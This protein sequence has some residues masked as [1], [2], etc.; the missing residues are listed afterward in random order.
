MKFGPL[1]LDRAVGAISAHAIKVDGYVLKKG[2]RVTEADVA[3]L[4]RRGVRE[5][6][7]AELAPDDVPED[8]AAHRIARALAGENLRCDAP[9]T[10][11]SN[12]FAERA[13]VVWSSAPAST[14]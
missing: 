5:I 1:P 14:R 6:T 7:A 8:E 13:G 4:S 10:G 11:R 2:A 12:L 9:F 3:A